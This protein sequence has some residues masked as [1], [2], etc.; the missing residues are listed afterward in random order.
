M[1]IGE[2]GSRAGKR[3]Y[4]ELMSDEETRRTV[5]LKE[6]LAVLPAFGSVYEDIAYDEADLVGAEI[7]DSCV[8]SAENAMTLDRLRFFCEERHL[9]SPATLPLTAPAMHRRA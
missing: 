6:M 4:E 1:L 7:T 9:R 8:N 3:L 2:I 5:A